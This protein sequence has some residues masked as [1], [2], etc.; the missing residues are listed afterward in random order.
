MLLNNHW[1]S[2]FHYKCFAFIDCQ[3]ICGKQ[4]A[5]SLQGTGVCLGQRVDLK[6][7]Q[8][9]PTHKIWLQ[10]AGFGASP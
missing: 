2:K 10:D 3:I 4:E 6:L 7:E 9:M 8:Y 5:H 1:V